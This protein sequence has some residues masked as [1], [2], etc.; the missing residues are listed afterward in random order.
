MAVLTSLSFRLINLHIDDMAQVATC[1]K[2]R[3]GHS[4]LVSGQ[5]KVD[6]FYLLK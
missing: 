1:T 4:C 5:V 2:I 6:C 3:E